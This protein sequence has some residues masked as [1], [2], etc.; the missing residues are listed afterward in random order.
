M[1]SPAAS[2]KQFRVITKTDLVIRQHPHPQA[3]HTGAV[4]THDAV[5]TVSSIVTNEVTMDGTPRLKHH[6]DR[7]PDTLCFLELSNGSGWV[8]DRH[9][10]TNEFF[11]ERCDSNMSFISRLRMNLRRFFRGSVYEWSIMAVIVINA[12]TIGAEID[13]PNWM[14]A[15]YWIAINSVFSIVYLT[16]MLTKL[17]ALGPRAYF[18]SSWN[19]FDFLVTTATLVGDGIILYEL[20]AGGT[21]QGKGGFTAVVPVLRLLRILRIAKMFQE[22]RVL[23]SS[24]AGSVSALVWIA[25]LL[26]LWFFICA[27]ICTTFVGRRQF[28]PDEGTPGAQE[29]RGRFANIPG[30]MYTLFEV[31]TLEGWTD[32]VRPLLVS[33]PMLVAFFMFF[34]FVAAFFLLNLVTAVVVDRTM[35]SQQDSQRMVDLTKEDEEECRMQNL[36]SAL[37]ASNA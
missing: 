1:S 33:H 18:T 24:F 19:S 13:H 26:G 34:V 36:H 10:I 6:E 7:P 30:S 2:G 31:M 32:V 35:S 27:C 14:P 5:F 9:L 8:M 3:K 16:E 11:C 29:L 20:A 17:F 22:M 4:L 28:L 37:L 15:F 21:H 23:I 12:F 25:M